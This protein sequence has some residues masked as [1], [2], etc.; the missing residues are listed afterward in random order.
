MKRYLNEI[1]RIHA[2]L[3]AT[4]IPY[5]ILLLGMVA[6]QLACGLNWLD[7]CQKLGIRCGYNHIWPDA[8]TCGTDSVITTPA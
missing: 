1:G 8:A 5:R 4:P 3:P 7:F 6:E 2:D